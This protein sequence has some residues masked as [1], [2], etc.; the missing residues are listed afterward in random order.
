MFYAVVLC[1][2]DPGWYCDHVI[3]KESLALWFSLVCPRWFILL[4]S[5]AV[6]PVFVLLFVALWFILRGDLF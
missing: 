3:G 1:V 5:K 2:E 6:V 4:C